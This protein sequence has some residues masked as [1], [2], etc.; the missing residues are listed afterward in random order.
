MSIRSSVVSTS[1]TPWTVTH[2]APISM[3]LSK[4]EYWGGLPF[5][6]PEDPPDPGILRVSP[7]LAGELST[8]EPPKSV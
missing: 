3:A 4:Q 5:P 1:V 7:A 6:P 2:R 8:T